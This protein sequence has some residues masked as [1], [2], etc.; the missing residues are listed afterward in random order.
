MNTIYKSH[1][2]VKHYR[3]ISTAVCLSLF[4]FATAAF[5]QTPTLRAN[6]KIAFTS[7]RD[8]NR[9]IYVMNNDGTGQVR[10]TNN[11]G[12]DS[13]PAFSPDGRKIAFISQNPSPTFAVNIKLMNADGTNQIELT[14]ITYFSSQ[15]PWFDRRSLSWSPDGSKIAFE[16]GGEILTINIDGTNRTNLTNQTAGDYE[17][18]FSPDGSRILFVSSRVPF[19]VM[20]TMNADGSDVRALP[21]DGYFQDFSP[22]WSPTGDKIV[23]LREHDD[24]GNA[25]Y[26]AN[27]DGTN[28]QV[29]NDGYKPKWSPDGTKIV[30][31]KGDVNNGSEIYVKN[32]DGSG[33]TQLTDTSGSNFQPSWQPLTTKSRKRIRFF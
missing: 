16:D 33:L 5:A 15:N 7:D 21:S 20:H 26:T 30:F 24:F 17:P 6:G 9:E 29:F 19:S 31:H 8:G 28:R 3:K 25:L 32:V 22:D 2:L 23:F 13:F 11:I 4:L 14:P 12:A 1:I 10:L 27:A 18:A